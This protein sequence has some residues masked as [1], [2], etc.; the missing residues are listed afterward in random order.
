MKIIFHFAA[1][2]QQLTATQNNSI[3]LSISDRVRQEWVPCPKQNH[4]TVS[5]CL[6]TRLLRCNFFPPGYAK[7]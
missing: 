6:A 4:Q 5:C 1:L 3:S 7:D 2:F